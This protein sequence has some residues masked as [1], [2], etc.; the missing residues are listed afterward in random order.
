MRE[1]SDA[2]YHLATFQAPNLKDQK[3]FTF[4]ANYTGEPAPLFKETGERPR[5]VDANDRENNAN[6]KPA[7][8]ASDTDTRGSSRDKDGIDRIDFSHNKKAPKTSNLHVQ[9][10]SR[11]GG[12][13]DL[14]KPAKKTKKKD[15]KWEGDSTGKKNGSRFGDAFSTFKSRMTRD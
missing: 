3:S 9:G 8:K 12:A 4:L 15:S 13:G 14:S 2:S 1:R 11:N 5:P 7:P 10:S 6:K